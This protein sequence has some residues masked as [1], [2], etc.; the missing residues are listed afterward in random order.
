M[1]K[2]SIRTAVIIPAL[3]VLIA[4]I[5]ILVVIISAIVSATT[6]KLTDDLIDATVNEYSGMFDTLCTEAYSTANTLAPVIDNIAKENPNPRE[7]IIEALSS[8]LNANEDMLGIWTCWESNALDGKDSQYA[9]T[10]YHDATGRFIP[11]IVRNGSGITIEPLSGYAVEGEGDYYL[12]ARDSGK[13]YITDPFSYTIDGNSVLL[14]SIAIPVLHDG[15]TVGVVGVNI[16]LERLM[17]LM[18]QARL[19]SNGY[20][21]LMSPGGLFATHPDP[22]LLLTSYTTTALNAFSKETSGVLSNGGSFAIKT[23]S[24]ALKADVVY[25][26]SGV[27]IGDTGRYWAVCG[28]VPQKTV[29]ASSAFLI[30]IA[31]GIGLLVILLTG[32]TILLVINRG[33]RKLPS[34]TELAGRVAAGDVSLASQQNDTSPTKNEITLLERAFAAITASIKSQADIMEQI[35]GGDYSVTVPVRCDGDVMN[36]AINDMVDKTNAT[37]TQINSS[38]EQ[39]SI[40]PRHVSEGAQA[41]AQGST[42]QAASV[43]ELSSAIAQ[44]SNMTQENAEMSGRAAKLAATIKGNAQNSAHQMDDMMAAVKDI[45]QASQGI[46]KV[47]KVIDDIAFQTNILALNAAVE[48]AR[49][50]Q[51]GKGF[52]VVAG[53]VRSLAAK[54]AEAAKETG[55]MI[56]DAMEK[57][58]LG[59]RIAGETAGSLTEIVSGIND[60]S[61][62]IADIAAASDAQSHSISQINTGIEQVVQVIQQNSATAEESAAASEEMSAQSNML[63]GL[64]SQFKLKGLDC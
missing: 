8:V 1:N 59:S 56:Q 21:Y 43:E 24:S 2:R 17:A 49:A 37:L 58:E 30:R 27:M 32:A 10:R 18:K 64:I 40:G 11:Y 4:G 36:R 23:Y 25:L 61:R 20:L 46:S 22:S 34:I 6:N 12:K 9:N 33:L 62:L 57:A 35:A 26:A 52:A 28:L 29:D 50:G 15:R 31:A 13:P 47:I 42:Q 55:A 54:S 3:A 5:V 45:N 51:H 44:I 48:A 16:S 39:V 60:S 63:R 53:E 14:Y 41:L 38:T 19:L 7:E